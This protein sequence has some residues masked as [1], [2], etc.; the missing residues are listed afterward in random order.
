MTD[1]K[2]TDHPEDTTSD[3]AEDQT[4]PRDWSD[5]GGATAVGPAT[6]VEE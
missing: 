2:R 5:E 1:E 3:P 6:D 4:E